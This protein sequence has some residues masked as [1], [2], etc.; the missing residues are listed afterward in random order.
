[1][2]REDL[3]CRTARIC[4]WR[5]RLLDRAS[6]LRKYVIGIRADQANRAHDDHKNYRQHDGVF[7]DVLSAFIRPKLM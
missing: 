3:M 2:D 1:M 6:N 7:C 5:E 4:E